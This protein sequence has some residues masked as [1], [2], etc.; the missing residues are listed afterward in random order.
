MTLLSRLSALGTRVRLAMAGAVVAVLAALIVV[1]LTLPESGGDAAA[2]SPTS[3]SD[4][5]G[6]PVPATPSPE[7][8]PAP[9]TPTPT[10]PTADVDEPPASVDPV[11]LDEQAAVGN[12]I[13]AEIVSLEAIDGTGQGPGN[14]AGPALRATIR[15]TNGTG[16]E[17]GLDGVAVSMGHGVDLV[18]ASPLDDPSAAPFRGTVQPGESADGVYVFTVPA[19]DRDLVSLSVGYQAGAPFLVFTGPAR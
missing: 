17:V 14:V 13:T 4:P 7:L 5:T 8:A 16:E 6:S 10:G 2:A 3:P 12:G 1:P 19:D 9:V 11:S 18:P 15:L